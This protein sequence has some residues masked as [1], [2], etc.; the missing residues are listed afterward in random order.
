MATYTVPALLRRRKKQELVNKPDVII[1]PDYF[2]LTPYS[3]ED[4]DTYTRADGMHQTVY[5]W[6]Q[7]H[8]SGVL[9]LSGESGTGKSSLLSGYVIP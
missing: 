9:Y 2:R 4:A 7:K 5:K 3:S 8:E 6:L 1:P